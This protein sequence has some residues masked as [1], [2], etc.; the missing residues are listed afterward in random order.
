MPANRFLLFARYRKDL[1]LKSREI[2]MILIKTQE[3]LELMQEALSE[4]PN[5]DV[6]DWFYCRLREDAW[7][8]KIELV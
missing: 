7:I 8:A 3:D 4:K 6:Y 5:G 2:G 1:N